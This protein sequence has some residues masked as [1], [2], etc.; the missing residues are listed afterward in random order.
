MDGLAKWATGWDS[1]FQRS[2]TKLQK[3]RKKRDALHTSGAEAVVG[4]TPP[5]V[6]PFAVDW[7]SA[8][9]YYFTLLITVVGTAVLFMVTRSRFG[10]ILK[11]IRENRQRMDALGFNTWLYQYVAFIAAGAMAGVAGVLFAYYSGIVAPSNVDVSQSGLLVLMIIM[12]GTGR[13]WGGIIGAVVVQVTA[14]FAQEHAPDHQNLVLGV[15]FVVTLIVLRGLAR[16][17][18]ARRSRAIT[19][20]VPAHA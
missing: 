3:R 18:A 16:W 1:P 11:G 20:E 9:V 8:N 19:K 17:R 7:T 12:G 5:T 15:L 10:T 2:C 13:L 14:F 4:I 6:A